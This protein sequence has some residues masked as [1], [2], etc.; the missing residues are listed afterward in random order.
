[1]SSTFRN[2]KLRGIGGAFLLIIFCG[3]F[4]SVT[5]FPHSHIVDGFTIVHSHPYKKLPGNSPAP[6]NHSKNAL[7]L[8]QFLSVIQTLAV[9]VLTGTILIR[10]AVTV[11]QGSF[12]KE[13]YSSPYSLD[14]H[15]PRAPT[16]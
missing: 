9:G 6:H 13:W 1:M 16:A 5:F 2:C 11:I 4:V 8:I 14:F 3:F 15:R 10:K 7:V 12:R